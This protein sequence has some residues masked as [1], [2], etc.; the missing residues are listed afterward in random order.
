MLNG[1]FPEQQVKTGLSHS[2]FCFFPA[3]FSSAFTACSVAALTSCPLGAVCHQPPPCNSQI[4]SPALFW[5]PQHFL[6]G[7]RCPSSSHTCSSAVAG[8]G[9]NAA[10]QPAHVRAAESSAAAGKSSAPQ[11][12]AE[13]REDAHGH[14][15]EEPSHPLQRECI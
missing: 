14:V 6:V 13:R 15:Q 10:I 12:P 1:G 9:A 4:C 7:L 5:S 8:K 3:P 11:N 2:P